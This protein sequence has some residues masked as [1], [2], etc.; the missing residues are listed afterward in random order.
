MK[1]KKIA[2]LTSL[3]VNYSKKIDNYLKKENKEVLCGWTYKLDKEM[4]KKLRRNDF[5]IFIYE[6]KTYGGKGLV[7]KYYEVFDF[8]YFKD[9]TSPIEPDLVIH[10]KHNHIQNRGWFYIQKME[11][12]DKFR[13]WTEFKDFFTGNNIKPISKM[14]INSL[15]RKWIYVIDEFK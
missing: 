4:K 13:K 9:L 7:T 2:L 14:R 10:S 1:S 15:N 5:K 6:P 3:D 8:Y 12:I 11:K